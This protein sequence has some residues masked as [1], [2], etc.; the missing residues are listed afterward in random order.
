[1][2]K[3]HTLLAVTNC[4]Y[5]NHNKMLPV[6][7]KSGGCQ[8]MFNVCP[9][10]TQE[11]L[12]K[13]VPDY[14]GCIETNFENSACCKGTEKMQDHKS[15]NRVKND[16]IIINV[17]EVQMFTYTNLLLTKLNKEKNFLSCI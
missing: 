16:I 17:H 2:D 12:P 4:N 8:E 11:T 9:S 14:T 3:I 1:V 13:H 10:N 6:Q 7:N 5:E 15:G